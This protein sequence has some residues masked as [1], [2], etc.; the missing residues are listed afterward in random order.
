MRGNLKKKQGCGCCTNRVHV[1]GINTIH[2]T[3]SWMIPY[4]INPED[5]KTRTFGCNDMGL[6]HCPVCKTIKEDTMIAVLYRDKNVHCEVCSD[7][8]SFPE[9]FLYSMFQQLNIKLKRHKRDFEWLKPYNKEYDLYF[10]I[11][12]VECLLEAHGLQHYKESF[13]KMLDGNKKAKSL[14]EEIINDEFK[15]QLALNNGIKED[16]YIVIDCR[17]STL[18]HIKQ[19]I[20]NH[21][22][23]T[24][25]FNLSIVD[26]S[27]CESEA[28]EPYLLK[29]CEYYNQG[30]NL[31]QIGD[32][33]DI[34]WRTASRYI[35]K[36]SEFGLCKY[37]DI[38]KEH[39]VN[40]NNTINLWKSGVHNNLEISDELGISRDSVGE[41]LRQA[42]KERLIE[43]KKYISTSDKKAI[44]NIEH[45]K[46]FISINEA[47]RCSEEIFGIKLSR[48]GIT[49]SC[50]TG[51]AYKGLHFQYKE[52]T[53]NLN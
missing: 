49:G 34:Y 52:N 17:Y 11:N 32:I 18:E 43:Y 28:N 24:T 22:T 12:G 20:L 41:Y 4:F 48:K 6:L 13:G 23:L 29:A 31:I 5:T 9:K 30:L 39:G 2:D 45:N 14:E 27:K 19:N 36:G 21:K 44:K 25:L 8:F 53:Y 7:G 46:E 38:K 33:M 47:H 1:L 26:W 51:K 37:K 50:D 16:N 42:E 10:I 3:D 35:R 40:F 15:K